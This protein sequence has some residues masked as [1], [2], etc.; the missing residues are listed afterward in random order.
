MHD[1][2]IIGAGPAGLAAALW[3]DQLGLDTLVLEHQDAVGGQL[4]SIFGPIEDYPGL[5]AR[6][7]REFLV[8]LQYGIDQAD[9]DL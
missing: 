5:R 6:D 2:L 9:F 3:C 1:V 4:F 8:G 7:G